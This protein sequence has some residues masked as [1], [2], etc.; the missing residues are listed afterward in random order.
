VAA[1]DT[2]LRANG[3]IED[4]WQQVAVY[5]TAALVGAVTVWLAA[6]AGTRR[7]TKLRRMPSSAADQLSPYAFD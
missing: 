2:A 4:R 7:R 3:T 5:L 6:K 1:V